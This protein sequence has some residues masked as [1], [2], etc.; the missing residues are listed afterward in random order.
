MVYIMTNA[1]AM[2]E[3]VAFYRHP[4]GML[5]FVGAYPSH[6]RGTGTREVSTATRVD[7]MDTLASQGSL[8]LSN[9]GRFLFAV[10]AGSHTISSFSI[11]GTGEPVFVDVKPSGGA[12]PNSLDV[13]GDL[14]YVSNV[15]FPGGNTPSNIA[16]F[17]IDGYGR[18]TYVPGST[19]YLSTLT[20]QP[21]RVVFTPDGTKLV[22]S[23]LTTNRLSVFRVNPDGTVTGPA[24]NRSNGLGPFGSCFLSSGV[25][26]VTEEK[27]SALSS[28]ALDGNGILYLIS[29]SVPNGQATT[30]WVVPS[31][32]ERFAYT[33]NTLSGTISTYRVGGTGALMLVRHVTVHTSAHRPVCTSMLASAKMEAIYAP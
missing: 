29:G 18:L 8:C 9:D 19:H 24:I 4:N 13:H 11:T 12:Q 31:R 23:E 26:L 5:T 32:D 30:C 16:G 2:N 17:R 3:V 21:A 22:V 20:A 27:S 15:G 6:G 10:N 14:L 28:Y 7:G 25:L 1:E 33:T